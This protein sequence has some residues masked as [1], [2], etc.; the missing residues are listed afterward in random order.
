[1]LFII[2]E[3]KMHTDTRAPRLYLAFLC[4]ALIFCVGFTGARCAM[5][6]C[7]KTVSAENTATI[8]L[9]FFFS[10]Y[11]SIRAYHYSED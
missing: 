3:I 11:L 9:E 7:E 10:L 4:I 8:L 6:M 5:L 1:M 2:Y